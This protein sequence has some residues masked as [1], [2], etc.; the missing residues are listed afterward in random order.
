MIPTRAMGN[1]G[2]D[3]PKEYCTKVSINAKNYAKYKND[4]STQCSTNESFKWM[5]V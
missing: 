2:E 3:T 1:S 4:S 5:D